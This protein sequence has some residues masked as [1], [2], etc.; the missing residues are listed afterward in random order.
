MNRRNPENPVLKGT[1]LFTSTLTVMAWTMIAPAL[2]SIQAHFAEVANVAFWVRLVL[3]LPA[4][5]IAATAPIAGYI[6]DRIGRKTVLVISTLL[7]GISGVAGYLAPTLTL[8]L[9]SR[10][11][12]GIAVGALMTSVTTLIA[13][14]YAGAARARFMGLQAG[15]MGLGGTAFLALGGVLADVGWRVP[16]LIYFFAFVILPFIVLALYEPL[17]GEQCAE[18]PHPI[19][20][21]G[22][23]VA[24]SIRATGSINSVGSIVSSVPIRFFLFVYL[25]MIGIEIVFYLI[26]VQLPFYLQALTGASASQSGLAISVMAFFYAL[27][28]LQYGRVASRLDHFEVLTIAFALVGVGY[29][30]IS[31][32]G[33][34]AIIVL[35]LLL[36]GIGLGLLIPNLNVWLAD[37]TPPALRGRVLGGLTTALFLGQFLSPIV[38]QPVSAIVGLGGLYL[39]AGALLLVIAPLFWVT[40]NQLRLLT[41]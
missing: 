31:S 38:G 19:S 30:L 39:S 21:P 26:P 18:K 27:A 40:R 32:A 8:L 16:F 5:F 9:I 6:V 37:E 22:E 13:D 11:S 17:L 23:C 28:S 34:W 35:G 24:E 3:T 2:P 12:L 14:Y 4:L 20:E 15:F 1:L 10:A 29:L 41:G 7:Y 25:V 33:G 36:G